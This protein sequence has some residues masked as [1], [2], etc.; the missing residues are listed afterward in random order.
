MIHTCIQAYSQLP[1][2]L[3][4]QNKFLMSLIL[5][6]I[7]IFFNVI[8]I[9]FG[10]KTEVYWAPHDSDS[11]QVLCIQ[12]LVN[13]YFF[14]QD[15]NFRGGFAPLITLLYMWLKRISKKC[16]WLL[17]SYSQSSQDGIDIYFSSSLSTSWQ[18]RWVG[19]RGSFLRISIYSH[20]VT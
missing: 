18:K 13:H 15:F 8:T 14:R 20:L 19:F 2:S 11:N 3:K 7:L 6:K 12:F 9:A 17:Q 5:F 10:K 1:H 4:L 16:S